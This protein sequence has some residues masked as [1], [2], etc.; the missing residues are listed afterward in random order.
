MKSAIYKFATEES[1]E[2][3]RYPIVCPVLPVNVVPTHLR[4]PVELAMDDATC[5]YLQ[6]QWGGRGFAGYPHLAE[7]TT[8]AEYR[9][10]ASAMSTE[11]TRKWIEI[12]TSEENSEKKKQIEEEFKRLNLI[13]IIQEA[14]EHDCYFG[15]GQ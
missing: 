9:A 15:R 8:R 7:L 10:F 1:I 2:S 12:Q 4:A 11:I 6:T 3:Y 14:A 5:R 13:G